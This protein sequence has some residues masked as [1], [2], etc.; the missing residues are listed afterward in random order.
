MTPERMRD[1]LAIL[2]WSQRG[3]ADI[4]NVDE[5]RVRKWARGAGHPM[6]KDLAVW[7]ERR[8]RAMEGDPPPPV[9]RARPVATSGLHAPL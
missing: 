6:P 1:C 4:I 2:G 8:A 5:A 3:F 7:L 9:P